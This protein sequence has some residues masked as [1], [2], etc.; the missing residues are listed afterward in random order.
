MSNGS[1]SRTSIE[2]VAQDGPP[3]ALPE[4]RAKQAQAQPQSQPADHV[5]QQE[6]SKD[7]VELPFSHEVLWT[8]GRVVGTMLLV[9][10][11]IGMASLLTWFWIESAILPEQDGTGAQI[12]EGYTPLVFLIAA[13]LAAPV[14][15]SIVGIFEGRELSTR[16]GVMLVGAGCFVGAILLV[17]TAGVFVGL[18]GAG[19]EG[20]PSPLDL[21]TLAGLSGLASVIVGALI[22]IPD[23]A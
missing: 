14:V 8:L 18:S 5:P 17:F 22:S 12:V 20:G 1:S 10:V 11:G 9:G 3:P 6:K 4:N 19:G 15:A 21:V 2:S 13:A 16:D 7:T 23:A